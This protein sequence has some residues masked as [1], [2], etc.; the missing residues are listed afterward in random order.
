MNKWVFL[1]TQNGELNVLSILVCCIVH[2]IPFILLA[3]GTVPRTINCAP[4]SSYTSYNVGF[5][6]GRV[7]EH[8]IQ[9]LNRGNALGSRVCGIFLQEGNTTARQDEASCYLEFLIVNGV[10]I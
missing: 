8:E 5:S 4:K 3:S 1:Q 7:C 9:N 6:C 2:H 10:L